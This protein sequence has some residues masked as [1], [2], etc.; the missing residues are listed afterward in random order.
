MSILNHNDAVEIL[1][2]KKDDSSEIPNKEKIDE[3]YFKMLRRYP[4]EMFPER[5]LLIRS[6]YNSLIANDD[7]W[8]GLIENETIDVSSFI[9]DIISNRTCNR[10]CCDRDFSNNQ[11]HNPDNS[12]NIDQPFFAREILIEL[13]PSDS[14]K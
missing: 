9:S 13:F 2:L 4:P 3:A 6:A 11:S 5:A 10:D 14:K 12:L 1:R 8:K 7:F